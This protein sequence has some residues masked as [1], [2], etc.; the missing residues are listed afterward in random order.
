MLRGAV[1]PGVPLEPEQKLSAIKTEVCEEYKLKHLEGLTKSH[2]LWNGSY[3]FLW[4]LDQDHKVFWKGKKK[5]K[6]GGGGDHKPT[7]PV[8]LGCKGSLF[9]EN[10]G[11]KHTENYSEIAAITLSPE[12]FLFVLHFCLL[13][14]SICILYIKIHKLR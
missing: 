14:M 10:T 8:L 13:C 2:S 12:S 6:A 9:T 3:R 11:K 5:T 7:F 4:S 1:D